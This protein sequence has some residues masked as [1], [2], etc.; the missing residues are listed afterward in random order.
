MKYLHTTRLVD[1]KYNIY[2][3]QYRRKYGNIKNLKGYF[4]K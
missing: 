3:C 2:S 1:I 4:C